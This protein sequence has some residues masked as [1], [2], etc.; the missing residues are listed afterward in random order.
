MTRHTTL[1]LAALVAAVACSLESPFAAP[2]TMLQTPAPP[3]AGTR[4]NPLL[5]PSPLPFAAPPFDKIQDADFKPAFEAGMKAQLDEIAA[6]A[7][8]P[9]PA[10]FENTLVALERS[11]QLLTR[12]ALAFNGLSSANTNPTLQALQEEVAPKLAAQDDAIFLNDK[13][14]TRVEA[15]YEA[16][17]KLGLQGQDLRLAEYYYRR[18]VRSGAKLSGADKTKLK[19]LN[20]EDAALSAKYINMLLAAAKAGALVTSNAADLAGLSK[21]DVQ[22]AAEAAKARGLEGQLVLPLQN[23]TQQ[24][25]L[26]SLTNRATRERLF[27]ASWT[28]TEKGDATDTRAT[29]AKLAELRARRAALLGYP[30]HAAWSVED[31]MAGTPAA[32]QEF[33]GRLVPPSMANARAEARDLQALIDKQ[34]GG[35]KLAPWDWDFY[36]EQ[37]RKARYDLNNEVLAPYFSLDRV[38]EDGVFFTA[39]ALYGLTF[40]ERRDIPVYHPDVKVYEVFDHDGSSLALF[41]TDYFKRDNKNGGAWMDNFVQQSRLFGTKPVVVNVANFTKP[42]PGQPALLTFDDVGTLFHEFGHALHGIFADSQY[43]TLS[44]ANV[45]RD[46]VELPSQINEHWALDAKVLS[47]YAVH[48]QTGQPLPQDLADKI[49]K[50]VTFNQG[51]ALTEL[52]GSASLDM[53]WHSLPPGSPAPDANAFEAAA[54]EKAGVDAK[55]VPP[56]Y[57]SSYFLHIWANGY[58]AGYYAYLWAEMLDNDAFGWFTE[59]GGLT[60]AN[61]DRFRRMILSRGNVSDY[62]QL[63]REFRGKDPS[64]EPMLRRRGIVVQR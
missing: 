60:R 10:T 50:A 54:L 33:L 24:P 11:G 28:R 36:A 62:A 61:G 52:L 2:K 51:Y 25:A 59:N 45:A 19:A 40:K 32:V 3:S 44:G 46:F 4:A 29:V 6:I 43:P 21:D 48:H 38:L 30:T 20:E 53:S 12:V 49:R 27:N 23:T 5:T 7:N 18:F 64:I 39:E 8:N 41:Y 37:V 14:F 16:R 31:Q 63:Y 35:F 26:A 57:R 13:L 55:V 56:R 34:G 9:E 17:A 1:L 58:D 42:A 47:R 15:V 22:A